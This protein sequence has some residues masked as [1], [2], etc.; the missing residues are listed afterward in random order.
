M[1]DSF[2]RGE[3]SYYPYLKD[4]ATEAHSF[5]ELVETKGSHQRPDGADV[6]RGSH[7][8]PY[9]HRVNYDAHLQHL[10][11]LP[12]KQ[13]LLRSHHD[14]LNDRGGLPVL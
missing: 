1:V 9:H 4:A 10:H 14:R 2:R 5:E 7:G 6:L 12:L 13:I 8:Q 11:G 3:K